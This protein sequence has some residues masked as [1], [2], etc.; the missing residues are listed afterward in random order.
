MQRVNLFCSIAFTISVHVAMAASTGDIAGNIGGTAFAVTSDGNRSVIAGAT[1]LLLTPSSSLSTTTDSQ[2]SFSFKGVEPSTYQIEATAPGMAGSS[3]VTVV[4][5]TTIQVPV[6]LHPEVIRQSVTVSGT[7][8]APQDSTGQAVIRNSTVVNAPNRYEQ[9][10]NLLPLV[11]G[12]VRGPDGLI[13]MKGARSSQAG[14]LVNGAG[15]TDP[16]TGNPAINLP[17]D[18]V[19]SISVI[20]NPYD[21]EY[22]R[23]AGAV[24][25]VATKTGNFDDFHWSV[26]NPFVRPRKRSGD[27]IG[28]ESA[29]PRLIATGPFVKHRIAFTESFEYRFVRIPV[30]SLPQ[31]SARHEK[32]KAVTSFSQVDVNLTQRQSLTASFA[33]YPQKYNYSWFELRSRPRR[34]LR[35]CISAVTWRRCSIVTRSVATR[36][37]SRSSATS[38]FDADTTA[39]SVAPYELP[40]RNDGGRLF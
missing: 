21:P 32:W 35:T 23:L 11:P 7:E 3:E 18:V 15:V 30:E 10:E 31:P 9:F 36:C 17:I 12:V 26:Q 19:E 37:S 39:N 22:G 24:S 25:E 13:N 33:L 27:F 2:G 1:V 4:D 28:I 20:S 16:A 29:T 5:G 38:D 34:P 6:E 40:G 14:S 8:D